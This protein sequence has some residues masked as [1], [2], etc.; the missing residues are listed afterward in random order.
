MKFCYCDE[1]GTGDIKS[2]P[3]AV[4]AGIVADSQRMHI[5]KQEW[6][7]LLEAISKVAGRE[8]AELHTCDFYAGNGRYR[9]IAGPVRAQIVD[10]IFD[11]LCDRKHAVIYAAV[12]R[13]KFSAA[14]DVPK[15]LRSYWRFLGFHLMLAAQK[16]G[17]PEEKTKGHT[18][19]VFD[20]KD[21]EEANL[22]DLI[23]RPPRWSDE[24]YGRG[25]KQ[26]A[27]DKIVDV[28]YFGDSEFLGLIQLADFVAYFLRRHAEIAEGRCDPKYK[29]EEEKV[30]RWVRAI[31]S[32]AEASATYLKRGR[33]RAQDLF[34]QLSPPSIRSL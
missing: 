27:L 17:Q 11:W 4:M 19:F 31:R 8:I 6:R 28:P 3:F 13:Q 32:R 10:S 15:E 7:A 5:T 12:D 29:G 24:Y 18:I 14:K 20:N 2:Q 22:P 25:P 1:S 9:D 16:L 33:N 21:K 34:Y 30:K 23:V 26:D